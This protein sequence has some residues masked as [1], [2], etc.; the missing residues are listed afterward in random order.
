MNKVRGYEG[1]WGGGKWGGGGRG[2]GAGYKD[3]EYLEIKGK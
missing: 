1:R 2:G 3:E